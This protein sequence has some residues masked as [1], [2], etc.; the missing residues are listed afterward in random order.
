VADL[1]S[2]RLNLLL[3]WCVALCVS[4][5]IAICGIA[6]GKSVDCKPGVSDGQC[7]LGTFMG[8]AFGIGGGVAA[9]S[10]VT[11]FLLIVAFRRRRKL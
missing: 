5:A 11:V 2:N 3:V 9:L 7:G 4:V 8:A 10:T 1:K 6:W